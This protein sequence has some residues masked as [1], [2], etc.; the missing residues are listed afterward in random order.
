[1]KNSFFLI[2]I[3]ALKAISL[4]GEGFVHDSLLNKYEIIIE[5]K[6]I[7]VNVYNIYSVKTEVLINQLILKEDINRSPEILIPY[8]KFTKVSDIEILITDMAGKKIKTLK[9][10]EL[11]D[12]STYD[13]ITIASD[14]RYLCYKSLGFKTPY[15]ISVKYKEEI[16]QSFN[17]P[18]F[19]TTNAAS[20]YFQ[21]GQFIINCFE[22]QNKIFATNGPYLPYISSDKNTFVEYKWELKNIKIEEED[23]EYF[24]KMKTIIQ[25]HLHKFQMEGYIGSNEN[26]QTFGEW[27]SKLN[28]GSDALD[29]KAKKEILTQIKGINDPYDKV[30]ILYKYLQNNMRYVSVQLG[31]GGW[32]P[33]AAQE[34]HD[35]KYGDCKALSNYMKAI[36]DIAGVQ[37]YYSLVMAGVFEKKISDT[38]TYNQFNHAILGVPLGSDTLFLECTAS[39]NNGT[40]FQGG[41]TH[42]RNVLWVDGKYSK[43]VNT[44][45]YNEENSIIISKFNIDVFNQ[46]QNTEHSQTLYG[47]AVTQNDYYYNRNTNELEKKKY[48]TTKL[49]PEVS[50]FEL[51][52]ARDVKN[53][54]YPVVEWKAKYQSQKL[55]NYSGKRIFVNLIGT[56]LTKEIEELKIRK[57]SFFI[58]DGITIIDTFYLKLPPQCIIE[59]KAKNV[60]FNNKFGNISLEDI[61]ES[62]NIKIVSKIV[63]KGGEYLSKDHDLFISWLDTYY[64][65][66]KEKI[67]LLCEK[68]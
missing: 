7:K 58:N 45:K 53:D 49:L 23:N 15:R 30:E 44:T 34:V 16:T 20:A 42:N 35:N 61:S 13:G 24:Q 39:N 21:N 56:K 9:K 66:R 12:Q 32:K 14:N 59:K 47:N 37:S 55:I 50:L 41:F 8:D 6:V 18:N 65:I 64:K 17:L 3:A 29:I 60:S 2:L 31:I 36:L 43:L 62:D 67:I 40:G 33:M 51:M 26:W 63:L 48:F 38:I 5:D 46:L 11:T 19:I 25:P 22:K 28:E 68:P 54:K 4:Y 1:M 52:E 27:I 10:S 57:K